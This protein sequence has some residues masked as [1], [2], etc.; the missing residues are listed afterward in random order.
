MTYVWMDIAFLA[1]AAM[2]AQMGRGRVALRAS[3]YAGLILLVMTLVF[4]NLIIGTG[5]VAYENVKTLGM[6]LGLAPIEDFAYAV[7]AI[8]IVPALWVALGR[9]SKK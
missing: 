8:V 3:V 9:R 7:A 2:I 5:I 1:L 4:D 6:R